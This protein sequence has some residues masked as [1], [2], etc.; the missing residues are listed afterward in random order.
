MDSPE[1]MEEI[2]EQ[3]KEDGKKRVEKQLRR[4][5]PPVSISYRLMWGR[6]RP[7]AFKK[8][9]GESQERVKTEKEV[10]KEEV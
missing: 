10:K 1:I 5:K 8:R 6:G 7:A 9:R 2:E 4:R 3:M